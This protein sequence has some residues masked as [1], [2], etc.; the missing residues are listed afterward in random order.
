M[1][2]E[3]VARYNDVVSDNDVVW[4]LGDLSLGRLSSALEWVTKMKGI[5]YF[6]PGNHDENWI[7]HKKVRPAISAAY[8]HAGLTVKQGPVDHILGSLP[9]KLS[10]FPQQCDFRKQ[11]RAKEGEDFSYE[12]DRFAPY[13][14]KRGPVLHGHVHS[15][16]KK[17]GTDVNVG[18]DVWNYQPVDA[19]TL[20]KLLDSDYN[21]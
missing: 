5:K 15:L 10:H 12:P 1:D 4:I 20:I 21:D 3:L 19:D 13:R 11:A 2:R 18:V 9:V 14:P 8:T 6:V 7:G 16:W 17:R